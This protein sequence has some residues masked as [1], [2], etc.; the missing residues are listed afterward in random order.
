MIEKNQLQNCCFED[1][2]G[3]RHGLRWNLGIFEN[4][5]KRQKVRRAK[6]ESAEKCS[7]GCEQ[8]PEEKLDE[9]IALNLLSTS[10]LT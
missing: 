1:R 7:F 4:P 8:N 3:Y 6:A 5:I 10:W 9:L 2:T